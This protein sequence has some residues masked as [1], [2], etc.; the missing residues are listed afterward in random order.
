M[1]LS[2]YADVRLLA[3]PR[4]YARTRALAALASLAVDVITIEHDKHLRRSRPDGRTS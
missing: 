3:D 1:F 2:L 4:C